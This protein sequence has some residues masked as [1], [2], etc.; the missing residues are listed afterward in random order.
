MTDA[1]KREL[2]ALRQRDAWKELA[3]AL[4]RLLT[5]YRGGRLGAAG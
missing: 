4:D 5:L 2:H 1:G 3:K